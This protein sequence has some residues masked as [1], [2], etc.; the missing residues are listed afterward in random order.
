MRKLKFLIL[1]LSIISCK[2]LE[3]DTILY[4]ND[5]ILIAFQS[6]KEVYYFLPDNQ[7]LY[8]LFNSGDIPN[9]FILYDDEVYLINSGGF[10][11]SPSIQKFNLLNGNLQVYPLDNNKN[12]LSGI[13]LNGKLYLTDF[14]KYYSENLIVFK[15][16]QIIDSIRLSNRPIDI[17]LWDSFLIVST[18]GMKQNY[19]YDS[20]SK[21]FKVSI[22]PLYKIDSLIVFPGASN[23]LVYK[24]TIFLVCSGIY[25]QTGARIY[26]ISKNFQKIDSI[27]ISRNIFN[28]D[29]NE[30]YLVLGSWDGW[31]YVL[32]HSLDILDSLKVSIS[33]N[34]IYSFSNSFYISANGFSYNPNYLMIFRPFSKVDS[35]KLSDEDLGIGPLIYYQRK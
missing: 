23:V 35:I 4:P 20:I 21:I 27:D 28:A 32:S 31:I 17:K 18:N 5:K 22:N 9:Y 13:Y 12:P 7:K 33:I 15:D 34:F 14:G 6:S 26:K 11:G 3:R 19:E 8:F 1:V 16:G 2:K 29:V 30:N 25:N 24:D 10:T